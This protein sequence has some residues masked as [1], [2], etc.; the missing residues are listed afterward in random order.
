[1]SVL[2]ISLKLSLK[3]F[4]KNI[5]VRKRKEDESI[6]LKDWNIY[7][8]NLYDSPNTMG[9]IINIPIEKYIFLWKMWSWG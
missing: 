8:K 9:N 5:I 7:L 6:P 2:F 4:C 1:M 3:K